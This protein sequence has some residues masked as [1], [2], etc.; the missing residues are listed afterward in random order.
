M[1][2]F[3]FLIASARTNGNSEQLARLAAASLDS[4]YVT[5]WLDLKDYPLVPFKDLRHDEDGYPKPIGNELALYE[6]SIECDELVLVTPVYWYSVPAPLKLY[7]D[8]WSAWMRVD[9]LEFKR[10]MAGKRMWAISASAG[11]ANEASH[12]FDSLKLS[13]KYMSMQWGGHV[14]GNGTAAGDVLNDQA[15]IEQAKTLFDQ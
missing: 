15:A 10:K 9:G 3:T 5:K 8:Y 1:P 6:A 7:L 12:M 11:P 14:I 2:N 4:N 13:A